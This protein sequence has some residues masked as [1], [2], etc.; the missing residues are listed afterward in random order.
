M[1]KNTTF[2]GQH[3]DEKVLLVFHQHPLVMRKQLVI[4]LLL[5]LLSV[6]PLLRVEWVLNSVLQKIPFIVFAIVLVYWFHRWVAWY[7][8]VYIFTNERV[9]EVKQSGFFNRKVTEFGLDKVQN[10][11]YHIKGFQ[12][13]LFQ[14]GEITIQTYVGDLVM[15]MIYKPVP[16][17]QKILKIVRDVQ[18]TMPPDL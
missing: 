14:F 16:I 15:P 8:S 4:G 12:A 7:Y 1:A 9:V 13:V 3:E 11:N 5:I 10:V 2:P 6:M 18:S 17:H